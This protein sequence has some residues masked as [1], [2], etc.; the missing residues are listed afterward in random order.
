MAT[1]AILLEAQCAFGRLT[2]QS[3]HAP[4]PC[5]HFGTTLHSPARQQNGSALLDVR[6]RMVEQSLPVGW[7]NLGW[8]NRPLLHFVQQNIPPLFPTEQQIDQCRTK[9]W[10][11]ARPVCEDQ[12]RQSW[13]FVPP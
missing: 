3:G 13:T 9:R 11:K 5:Q 6:V 10:C 7:R 12:R 1:A 4:I 8:R 2:F